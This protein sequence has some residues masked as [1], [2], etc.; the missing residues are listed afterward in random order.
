ME[1][2]SLQGDFPPLNVFGEDFEVAEK[3]KPTWKQMQEMNGRTTLDLPRAL[4]YVGS[5]IN[6]YSFGISPEARGKS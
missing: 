1:W 4:G 6:T 2:I 5:D 3:A